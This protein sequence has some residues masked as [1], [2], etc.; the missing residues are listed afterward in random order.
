MKC[1]K[2]GAEI[3]F[4]DLKPDCRHCGVNILY[5][6]QDYELERDAKRAEL[7]S[8]SAR[9]VIARIKTVFIGSI[10][11]VFRMVFILLSVCALMIPFCSVS[12]NLPFYDEKLS[13]GLIGI[14]QSFSDGMLT[15]LPAYIK[16]SVFSGASLSAAIVTGLFALLAVTDV[17]MFL[18]YLLGF[19]SPEKS[20]KALRNISVIACIISALAQ[21]SAPV[22]K[23]L[24]FRECAYASFSA[25]FGALVCAALHFVLVIINVK[26]LKKGISPVY[27]EFDPK[28]KE[29]LAKVKKG[30]VDLDSLPLPV[31]ES[32][33]EYQTRM[34][35][36]KHA[37]EEEAAEEL[38]AALERKSQ[39][40]ANAL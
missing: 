40:G 38:K 4:Y 21:I 29:L 17:A 2:C 18:V 25:G 1:P 11:A 30:E 10:H 15:A 20:A 6:T 27:R 26:M 31:F 35:E 9:M 7:E 28:R 34:N 22:C 24:V 19:L 12:F 13:V 33:E 8:A 39:E 5:Y 14:I 37:M 36:F 32:E 16:S 3:P 23:M